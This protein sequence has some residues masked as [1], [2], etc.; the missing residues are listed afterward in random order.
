M[1][2]FILSLVAFLG[3]FCLCSC[4]E[5]VTVTDI[6]VTG[7][8]T[9]FVVGDSFEQGD[10][11]VVVT[12]S[13]GTTKDVT[14]EVELKTPESLNSVGKYA[15]VVTYSGLSTVYYVT[16]A[17]APVTPPAPS[18]V[19]DMSGAKLSYN[20][21]ETFSSEGIKVYEVRG[22][23]VEEVALSAC[24][25]KVTDALEAEVNGAFTKAGKYSVAVSYNNNS[26]SYDLNVYASTYTSVSE[27][28]EAGLSHDGNVK[29]GTAVFN[30]YGM[31]T[32]YSYEFGSNLTLVNDGTYNNYYHL[33][34]DETVFGV[35]F[36]AEE[37]P[38]SIDLPS[39]DVLKGVDFRGL[40]NY[41][42]DIFGVND[43]LSYYYE[44]SKAETSLNYTS[45]I[46]VCPL[47]GCNTLY[48]FSFGYV[49]GA[50]YKAVDVS[51]ELSATETIAKAS[52]SVDT[53]YTESSLKY[54]EQNN[55]IGV[56]EGSK[57][58]YS[59]SVAVSQEEGER[60]LTTENTPDKYLF[61]N[62]DVVDSENKDVNGQVVEV[63]VGNQL[64]LSLANV[65][66]TTANASVDQI[67]LNITDSEGNPTWSV[68][69]SY[70]DGQI[71]VSAYKTGNYT[72]TVSSSKVTKSFT[73]KVNPAELTEFNAGLYENYGSSVTTNK[74]VYAGVGLEICAVV[75]QYADASF[76]AALTS[77]D[78]S[79]QLSLNEVTGRYD[80]CASVLGTYVI[81]LTSTV[82]AKFTATL[83]V[84]VVA[85]PSV[86]D[87]LNGTWSYSD[88]AGTYTFVF[89]PE[90]EGATS[91]TA[92]L[93]GEE[94]ENPVS[95]TIKYTYAEGQ[96]VLTDA[97]GQALNPED[98]CFW[99][100]SN[101]D[102]Y[103]GNGYGMEYGKLSKVE[104]SSEGTSSIAGTYV[105]IFV[106]P[107]NGMEMESD[108]ILN[109]DGTGEYHLLDTTT[110]NNYVGTFDWSYE[111]E[112]LVL[113]N[114]VA[115]E[116]SDSITISSAVYTAEG[117]QLTYGEMSNLFTK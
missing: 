58:D 42:E 67:K 45:S 35:K 51:F 39:N 48:S 59:S 10:L 65:N 55:V 69:G 23:A 79:A 105:N 117:I 116:G 34:A 2:K 47:C 9:E 52:V 8:K 37:N 30:S 115:G 113:S 85:A 19:L 76:T 38:S 80:F 86:A 106:H 110:G 73:L 31:E 25:V 20:V 77:G 68:Y 104:N 66:P 22:T 98:V 12:L 41:S 28:L 100:D 62:F 53:Y 5:V 3:L 61:A 78:N 101:L 32:S 83:T 64:A 33:L 7:P 71:T 13:D 111:N 112:T 14:A 95:A 107:K 15:V 54:D 114:V 56:V 96:L 36:D 92:E 44:L 90:S 84:E 26:S 11:S 88:Y 93:S 17:E 49:V 97:E 109:A 81:T 6:E 91:G 94:W 27:A 108:L 75:N 57:A 46:E 89:T 70:F 103:V 50:Q 29:G 74:T 102:L 99:I 87:I 43:L 24:T 72:V 16:V 4:S 60:T 21:G 18:L 82:D 40:V 1:K 63:S